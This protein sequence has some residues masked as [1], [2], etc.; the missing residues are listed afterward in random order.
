LLRPELAQLVQETPG[1]L[2][3]KNIS[4]ISSNGTTKIKA[5]PL[6]VASNE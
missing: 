5:E 4:L 6:I 2:V 1:T 3:I